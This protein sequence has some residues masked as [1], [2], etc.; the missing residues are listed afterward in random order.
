MTDFD[1]TI[2][3]LGASESAP[4]AEGRQSGEQVSVR[5]VRFGQLGESEERGQTP[6]NLDLLLDVPL[7][8][9]VELGRVTMSIGQILAL[10]PGSIVELDRLASEPVDLVVNDRL[11]A[12]GEVVLVDDNFGVRL[13]DIVSPAKRAVSLG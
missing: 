8:I 10:G 6:E 3:P 11:I 9:D 2:S 5:P 13:T 4:L 1:S 7:R 12:H